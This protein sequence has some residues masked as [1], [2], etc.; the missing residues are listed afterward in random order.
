MKSIRY[1]FII[2]ALMMAMTA[3]ARRNCDE[4]FDKWETGLHVGKANT[5]LDLNFRIGYLT[6]GGTSPLPIPAEIRSIN[7][8]TPEIGCNV[9]LEASAMF[10]KRF[11]LAV[12]AFFFRE[13]FATSANVKNYY[14]GYDQMETDGTVNEIKGW[15]TGT[16]DSKT[17][18]CGLNVP[19]L[20]KMR[21]SPRWDMA[22]GPFIQFNMKRTF[23]GSVYDGYLRVDE[24]DENGHSLGLGPTGAKQDL[25]KESAPTYDMGS[26]MKKVG[27]GV[28][29]VVDWRA[30]KHLSVF[31]KV[32]WGVTSVFPGSFETVRFKM[33]PIYA[34][35]GMAVSL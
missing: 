6:I 19:V 22:V 16:N 4:K 23:T 30:I 25:E 13:G 33:F 15:F 17:T 35:L 10:N 20:C 18:M 14:M 21:L 29:M 7:S 31:G 34:T 32:D 5:L 28:E 8:F 26:D 27:Y 2:T 9:G 12:G 24:L 1:I 3:S 11:G